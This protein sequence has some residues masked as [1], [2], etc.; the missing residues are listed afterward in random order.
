MGVVQF[1]L[2]AQDRGAAHPSDTS[3]QGDTAPTPLPSQQPDELPPISLISSGHK[4]IDSAMLL[5]HLA[6]GVALAT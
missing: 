1:A 2:T 3:Q 5:G 4:A 6:V